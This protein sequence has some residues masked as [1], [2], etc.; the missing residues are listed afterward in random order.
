MAER[1]EDRAPPRK[2]DN[3]AMAPSPVNVRSNVLGDS[4]GKF[5]SFASNS[6]NYNS[7]RQIGLTS[8]ENADPISKPWVV[9][10]TNEA[11]N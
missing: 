1:E 8:V 5:E 11:L 7:R 6:S 3:I 2:A 4:A 10:F 9:A